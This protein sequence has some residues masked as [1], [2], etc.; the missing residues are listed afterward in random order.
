MENAVGLGDHVD[1]DEKE[2]YSTSLRRRSGKQGSGSKRKQPYAAQGLTMMDGWIGYRPMALLE[3]PL[4]VKWVGNQMAAGHWM[5][6][7]RD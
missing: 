1:D 5:I 6:G 4:D 7:N 2:F 3:T